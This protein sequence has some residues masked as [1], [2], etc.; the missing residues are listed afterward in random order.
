MKAFILD[1]I[2]N[3]CNADL[4]VKAL[5]SDMGSNNRVM[6][7]C[8]GAGVSKHNRVTSFSLQD[9]VSHI[10]ADPCHL[11]KKMKRTMQTHRITLSENIEKS[12]RLPSN[13]VDGNYNTVLWKKKSSL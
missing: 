10:L 4:N 6:W 9:K 7:M 3:L 13:V 2:E 11:V 1:V 12:H 5:D 8:L